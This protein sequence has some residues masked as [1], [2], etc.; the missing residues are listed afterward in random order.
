MIDLHGKCVRVCVREKFYKKIQKNHILGKI[1][2]MDGCVHIEREE[3][4]KFFGVV[5]GSR[6]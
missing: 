4:V 2:A 3:P 1:G 5:R 6:C